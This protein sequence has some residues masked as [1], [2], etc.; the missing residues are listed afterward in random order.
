MLHYNGKQKH[1]KKELANDFTSVEIFQIGFCENMFKGTALLDHVLNVLGTFA[2][3]QTIGCRH[4]SPHLSE[5][6]RVTKL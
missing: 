5:H 3:W 2:Q 1:A 6:I 4:S